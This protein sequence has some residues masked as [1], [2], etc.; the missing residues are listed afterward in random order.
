MIRVC[1]TKSS[2]IFASALAPLHNLNFVI[3]S[4][5]NKV[6]QQSFY[7]GASTKVQ[8]INWLYIGATTSV[9][10]NYIAR[11]VVVLH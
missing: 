6:K 3:T 5:C 11:W 2:K 7:T 8:T 4:L 9:T 10:V 1:I